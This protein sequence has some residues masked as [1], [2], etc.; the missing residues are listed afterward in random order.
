[1]LMNCKSIVGCLVLLV[2]FCEGKEGRNLKYKKGKTTTTTTTTTTSTATPP[3]STNATSA[4]TSTRAYT[5]VSSSTLTNQIIVG[6]QGWF[7]Y[8]GDGAPINKWKHWFADDSPYDPSPENLHIDLYPMMDEYDDTDLGESNVTMPDGSKAKFYS[9]AKPNVVKKHFEW[10]AD[11]GISGAFH[12]RF[13]IDL[14]IEKNYNWKTGVLRNVRDAAEATGR[15]FAVSY[16]I[17]GTATNLFG[18]DV[19]DD[20]KNDWMK[21]VDNELITSSDR[22]LRNN[23]LPVLRIFGIGFKSVDVTDTTKL[24]ALINWFKTDPKYRVFLIG[25]VPSRWRER[26]GDSR[27]EIAWQGI[28]RSLNG[29]HPWHVARWTTLS[30]WESYY[31]NTILKDAAECVKYSQLYMPTMWPGFSWHN[32]KHDA[33]PQPPINQIP[34][35]GGNFMWQQAYRYVADKNIKTVWMAQFDEVDEGTAIFKVAKN[36]NEVPA[37]G[38][39]LSLDADGKA[40][41]NDW[42]LRLCGEAQKMLQKKIK[43]TNK[44]PIKP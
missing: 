27:Q 39:W 32:L 9:N 17:A 3:A 12:M 42:Y 28:Y 4:G 29:I 18:G 30:E 34:R 23:G 6:Y 11:Y 2:V 35:L 13:M 7:T 26:I 24:A 14:D 36:Q 41:P 37:D 21:L 10:M 33:S 38:D 43:L 44:I 19:L 22:Y 20:I 16:N 31:K 15:V 8:P 25:G 40:L 5:V 1:M